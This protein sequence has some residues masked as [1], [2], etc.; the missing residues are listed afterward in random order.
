MYVGFATT[1]DF[2]L[3][4]RAREFGISPKEWC[5]IPSMGKCGLPLFSTIHS[6]L[7]PSRTV[8]PH[9][10]KAS[11]LRSVLPTSGC[12]MPVA[13]TPSHFFS[14][15]MRSCDR[16]ID[17]AHVRPPLLMLAIASPFITR[18]R[19]SNSLSG[20]F[21]VP[22]SNTSLTP[23]QVRGTHCYGVLKRRFRPCSAAHP[24]ALS[25]WRLAPWNFWYFQTHWPR[26]LM[27]VTIAYT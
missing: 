9:L 23:R 6:T 21:V 5:E 16:S 2:Y 7:I 1:S 3:L 20:I 26:H 15:V 19:N 22:G 10:A 14:V 18:I 11:R 4:D 24:R 8:A 13:G 12:A 17:L 25:S 27:K